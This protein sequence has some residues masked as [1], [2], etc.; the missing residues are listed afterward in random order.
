MK[1]T[2]FVIK[3][4]KRK[5]YTQ[6]TARIETETLDNIRRIVKENNLVSVNEFIND[7]L[8]Y[9]I[10]NLKITEA[11]DNDFKKIENG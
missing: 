4:R 7:C 8:R 3:S 10:T 11:D 9:A 1:V 5:D 6:F 2:D